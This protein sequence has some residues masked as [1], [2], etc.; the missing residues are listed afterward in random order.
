M[1]AQGVFGD[2]DGACG[3]PLTFDDR[4]TLTV[5]DG[6][7]E[8]AQPSTGSVTVGPVA[9]DGTFA[10]V[11]NATEHYVDGRIDGAVVT[12]RYLYTIGDC[13]QSWAATFTLDAPI[14][15]P[16][17]STTTTTVAPTTTTTTT[18]PSTTTTTALPST[19]TTSRPI[20]V[21]SPSQAPPRVAERTIRYPASFFGGVLLVLMAAR[22]ALQS[23]RFSR[24]RRRRR[25]AAARKR[26]RPAAP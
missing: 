11:G 7:L 10:D 9:P 16:A 15:L 19:T 5:A 4:F 12:A 18:V 2:S 17:P 24:I 22:Y 25:A 6:N 23:R 26:A 20:P 21:P 3:Q 1:G 13:T 14:V 8:I